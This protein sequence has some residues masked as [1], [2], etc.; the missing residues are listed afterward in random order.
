MGLLRRHPQQPSREGTGE[1]VA[2]RPQ[3]KILFILLTQTAS[4]WRGLW[5]RSAQG[6]KHSLSSQAASW[7]ACVCL[8]RVRL[9][10]R[11]P[12]GRSPGSGEE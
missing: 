7:G 6:Y 2:G 10:C 8:C 3:R 1:V 12:A 4:A 5:A 9:D 11:K